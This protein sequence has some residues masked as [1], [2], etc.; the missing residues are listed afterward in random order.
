M[1][2]LRQ[3]ICQDIREVKGDFKIRF[4]EVNHTVT[5]VQ[6]QLNELRNSHA[7]TR[8]EIHAVKQRHIPPTDSELQDRIILYVEILNKM[9]FYTL[10][11]KMPPP[12][13]DI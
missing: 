11:A 8:E 12:D 10:S 6:K 3:V 13:G 5:E 1:R 2:Q 9:L 4:D 7:K